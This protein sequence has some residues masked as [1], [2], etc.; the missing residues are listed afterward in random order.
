MSKSLDNYIGIS[1]SPREIFGKTLSIPDRLMYDFFVLATNMPNAELPAIKTAIETHPRDTKRRL[2]KDLVT[3]YHDA[4]AATA[5][6]EEFDRI[7]VKKDV[8]DVIEEMPF[9]TT[10]SSVNI[11][12]LLTETNLVPSKGEARR[13]IEQGGVTVNNEKVTDAKSD[14]LLSQPMIIKVGKRKFLK[15]IPG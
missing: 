15:V 8:P 9:G 10:G 11:L 6:E 1:D 5:A 2:A 3:L 4:A 7:F 12:Q 14:I 13:L